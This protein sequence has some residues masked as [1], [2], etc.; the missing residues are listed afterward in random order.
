MMQE[1]IK[2]QKAIHFMANNQIEKDLIGRIQHLMSRSLKDT[3]MEKL[4]FNEI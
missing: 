4:S 3:S 1:F 2:G